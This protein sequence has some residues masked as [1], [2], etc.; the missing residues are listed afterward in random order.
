MGILSTKDSSLTPENMKNMPYLRACL[1]ESMRLYP[2]V[3]GTVRKIHKDIVLS[4]YQVPVNSTVSMISM[5]ELRNPAQFEH[6]DKFMP[7]RWLRG[8]KEEAEKC[9]ITTKTHHPYAFIPFGF[10]SRMCVGRRLA[11]LEMETLISRILRNFK[12]EWHYGDLKVKE[13]LVNIPISEMRF[14]VI[15]L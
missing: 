6:P 10:G 5:F 4:G 14:K 2:I 12:L 15:D 11:E 8:S 1:K 9:P 3:I 13:T 7:E